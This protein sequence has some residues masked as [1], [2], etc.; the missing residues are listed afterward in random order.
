M[1]SALRFVGEDFSKEDRTR[2][3]QE[4]MRRWAEQQLAEKA[5]ARHHQKDEDDLHAG[6]MMAVDEI[7]GLAEREEWEMRRSIQAQVNE[8]NDK[9]SISIYH[10]HLKTHS[11]ID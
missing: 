4:Q 2:R 1:S 3:Q 7:R 5:A 6:M 11:T 9:V 10:M 8:E